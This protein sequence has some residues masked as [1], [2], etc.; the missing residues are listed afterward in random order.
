MRLLFG[1][2]LGLGLGRTEPGIA[3]G[4]RVKSMST[5]V[6]A[7]IMV[8]ATSRV[9]GGMMGVK[10]G[11]ATKHDAGEESLEAPPKLET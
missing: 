9:Q 11:H 7:E 3:S 8:R 2:L 1:F 10:Q 5:W 6:R 4:P